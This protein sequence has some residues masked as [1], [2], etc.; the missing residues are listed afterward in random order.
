MRGG[1][2]LSPQGVSRKGNEIARLEIEFGY[3][4]VA[5]QQVNHDPTKTL[6][7]KIISDI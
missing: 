1:S 2:V 4:D 6:F 5:V 3:Y 7:K